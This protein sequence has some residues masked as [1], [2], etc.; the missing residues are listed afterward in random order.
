MLH[1]I[2]GMLHGIIYLILSLDSLVTNEISQGPTTMGE[3]K[4]A[5]ILRNI[6]FEHLVPE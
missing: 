5:D 3:S 1:T 4:M 2:V 6:N